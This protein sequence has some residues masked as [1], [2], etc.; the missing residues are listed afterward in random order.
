MSRI[1]EKTVRFHVVAW[2]LPLG[3]L[4]CASTPKE[5]EVPLPPDRTV[6]GSGSLVDRSVINST[7]QQVMNAESQESPNAAPTAAKPNVGLP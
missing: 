6:V 7:S 1:G 2:I 3:L 4:G 5:S